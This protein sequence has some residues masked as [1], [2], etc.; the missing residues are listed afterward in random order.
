MEDKLF[1]FIEKYMPLKEEEKQALLELNLFKYY[2][3][4][5][6]LLRE[7]EMS[8]IG[9]F[10]IQG[11]IRSY[12]VIHGE[13]KSTAFYTEMEVLNPICNTNKKPSSYF[14]SCV[15]DSILVVSNPGMEKILFEK[16][17]RFEKLCRILSEDLLA[18]NKMEFDDFKTSSPEQRYL[19]L[20]QL[21]PDLLQRVPQYQLASY[22]GVTPQSLSRMRGRLIE[23]ERQPN[24][25]PAK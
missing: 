15:E 7:G 17:P 23:K 8:D 25:Q 6:I 4:G 18:K 2:P 9:Y 1:E 11:M 12:Y 22:L 21:R 19:N 20:V 13:E 14:V 5:T 10:V 3:R 16:F 24:L